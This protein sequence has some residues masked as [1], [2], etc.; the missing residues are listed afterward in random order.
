MNLDPLLKSRNTNVQQLD[1]PV[2]TSN[3]V[4]IKLRLRWWPCVPSPP[5]LTWV[6]SWD[7]LPRVSLLM[8]LPRVHA[9][10]FVKS[11]F[12]CPLHYTFYGTRVGCI[13][14]LLH[15]HACMQDLHHRENQS[16][17]K[18]GATASCGLE[19]AHGHGMALTS[20]AVRVFNV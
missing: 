7:W 3:E 20:A 2:Y 5:L 4:F 16:T 9:F 11:F 1:A 17:Y 19:A 14:P 18:V 12:S 15:I 6:A 8:C 10:D 13:Q